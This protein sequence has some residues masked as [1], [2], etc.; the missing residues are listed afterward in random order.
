MHEVRLA[1]SGSSVKEKR[2]VGIAG[3]FGYR[4]T[5][6]VREHVVASDDERIEPVLGM[7]VGA[8]YFG[9]AGSLDRSGLRLGRYFFLVENKTDVKFLPEQLGD[10]DTEEVTVILGNIGQLEL[11]V[12]WDPYDDQVILYIRD[13]Q[14]LDPGLVRNI[15]EPVIITDVFLNILPALFDDLFVHK[16]TANLIEFI[17]LF[18]IRRNSSGP[19]A[20]II[21]RV[22]RG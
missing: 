16:S 21:C 14:V 5:R 12:R 9:K 11:I 18:I 4:K 3:R 20:G 6:G 8:L 13:L 22:L 7:K 10:G 2:I 1:Q 17:M 19:R 15:A